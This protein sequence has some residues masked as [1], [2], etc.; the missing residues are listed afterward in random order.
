MRRARVRGYQ[1]KLWGPYPALVDGEVNQPV[2]GIMCEILSQ[3]HMD[4]L[5]AYETDKYRLEYCFI[6]I[7]NDDDSVKKTINGVSFMWNGEE[8]ELQPGTFD[9]KEWKR[10]RNYE[11]RWEV[12]LKGDEDI[13]HSGRW[14]ET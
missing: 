12:G 13:Y 3:T 5:V 14:L 6:D 11:P 1:I 2:N 8:D 10:I 4:R 7:L 9:L